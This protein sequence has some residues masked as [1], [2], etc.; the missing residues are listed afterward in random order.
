MASVLWFRRDLRLTDLPSLSAAIER[1]AVAPLYVFDDRLLSGRSA[2]SNRNAVLLE[3][4]IDLDEQLRAK[5]TKLHVRHGNPATVV[6]DFLETTGATEVFASRDY[7]PFAR[8]RDAEVEAVLRVRGASLHLLPGT[9]VHEPEEVLKDSG[10]PYSVYSAFFRRWRESARRDA[11]GA[12]AW[13]EGIHGIEGGKLALPEQAAWSHQSVHRLQGGESAA[14]KRLA[15]VLPKI[16]GYPTN[17]DMLAVEGT[18]RLSQDLK[19]GALSPLHVL[20]AIPT[21][22]AGAVKFMSELAWR[23]FYHHVLWFHPRVLRE[24]FQER[25]DGLVWAN[26]D[27]R[28]KAW[29]EGR[30]GFPIVDAAM[31]QL[32][33]TGWMHNRAR[34]IV[35]S[36]LAKDLQI[37]WRWGESHF[38]R[39]LADGDVANN[40]GG[41]QWAAS[42]GTDAQP[43]FRVFNPRSQSERFDPQGTYIREW[44]PELRGVP[45]RYI[46]Q[47]GEMSLAQQQE[48]GCEMG[49]D[50]PWPIV[51]HQA[52]R[53]R[54][55]A[56]YTAAKATGSS[57]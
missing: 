12:P 3:C 9:L 32:L 15:A 30:T 34:M 26:D 46:H 37:D 42:T 49:R 47:P 38:M 19:F 8:R 22:S 29:K 27:G 45:S 25:F 28:F 40:N 17:R 33:A 6:G 39:W 4:L 56:R 44:V 57:R 11:L 41:W 54:A 13:I 48:A 52:E 20:R 53:K 18:S 16:G 55:I 35:A 23:D 21:V 14:L 5:G 50:Y 36:F 51:D 31:R 43:F 2:S 7:S 1:G 24:S 10:E